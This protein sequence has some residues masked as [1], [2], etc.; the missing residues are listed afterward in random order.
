MT[1]PRE[2]IVGDGAWEIDTRWLAAAAF[3]LLLLCSFLIGMVV[4]PYVHGQ[5]LLLTRENLAVK[6]YL[7]Q[8]QGRTAAAQK[9]H[10][11][12]VALLAPSRPGANVPNVFAASQRA[13]TAQ[14]RLT[15]LAA[16]VERTRVPSGL[17]TLDDLLRASLAA[18]LDLADRTMTF[19]GRADEA[20]R[21]EALAAAGEAQTRL[22]AAR[23]AW[24]G[25]AR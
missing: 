21:Q 12:L 1:T 18:E 16:E 20:S 23:Q 17:A 15:A 22:D 11:E 9:E 14:S 13:R 5:P 10:D 8:Y 19:V 24:Q 25:T 2:P 4:T 7:D 3:A 6:D